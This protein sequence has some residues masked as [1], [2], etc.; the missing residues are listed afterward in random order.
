MYPKSTAKN[1][2]RIR[3]YKISN[4]SS[5]IHFHRYKFKITYSLKVPIVCGFRFFFFSHNN[6]DLK[7]YFQHLR[8]I[9]SV[10]FFF[11]RELSVKISVSVVRFEK[12]KKNQHSSIKQD[13]NEGGNFNEDTF[14]SFIKRPGTLIIEFRITDRQRYFKLRGCDQY[15]CMACLI[16]QKTGPKMVQ[17]CE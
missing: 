14:S 17:H 5:W 9:R 10:K 15:G 11:S 16:W 8:F 13:C 4:K 6:M 7:K 3:N 2:Q 12:K 1:S